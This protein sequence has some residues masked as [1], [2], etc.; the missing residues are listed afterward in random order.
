[1]ILDRQRSALLI[2][3]VQERLAPAI[4]NIEEI[5]ARIELLI[6]AALQLGVPLAFTEQ[7]SA[8]LQCRSVLR[9]VSSE[10]RPGEI[11]P[12][13]LEEESQPVPEPP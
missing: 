7:Y 2:V 9:I 8:G 10:A 3:D 13:V 1:M 6:R 12:A 5:L 4:A 11:T